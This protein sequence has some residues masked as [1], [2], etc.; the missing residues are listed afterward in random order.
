MSTPISV[1]IS[2]SQATDATSGGPFD[3]QSDIVFSGGSAYYSPYDPAS[4]TT[5]QTPTSSAT[6]TG[7]A[8]A[9]NATGASPGTTTGSSSTG[10]SSN[11]L[12]LILLVTGAVI[13]GYFIYK[14]GKHT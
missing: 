8:G 14:H 2:G 1:G 9:S 3:V 4:Q 6:G 13:A 7:S 12:M 5:T 10:S 11:N